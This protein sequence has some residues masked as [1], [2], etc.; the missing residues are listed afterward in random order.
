MAEAPS[1]I[2]ARRL[3]AQTGWVRRLARRLLAD[4]HA[5][6]DV[7][8][9]TCL[10]A[11]ERPPAGGER[12]LRAWMAAVARNLAL[13]RRRREGAREAVERRA[14]PGEAAAGAGADLERVELQR[15]VV[16][17]LLALDEPYRSTLVLR[18]LDG[19]PPR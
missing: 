2:D 15:R 6:E 10:A 13:R 14:A 4:E 9:D 8:Q 19:L 17:E 3:L 11:L 7:V 18:Y 1:T 16:E 12:Q 5:A